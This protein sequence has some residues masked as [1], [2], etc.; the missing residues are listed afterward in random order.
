MKLKSEIENFKRRLNQSEEIICE[1]KE[2]SLEI[3]QSE[4]KKNK[5]Q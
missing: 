5:K 3:I 4:D 2:E 1:P